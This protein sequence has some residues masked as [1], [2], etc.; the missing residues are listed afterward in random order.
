[1]LTATLEG[2][3]RDQKRQLDAL[4]IPSSRRAEWK[5]GA[6]KPTLAQIMVLAMVTNSDPK[7]LIAWLA[8]QEATPAQ[9]E[10]FRLHKAGP[11][12]AFLTAV[13]TVL[14]AT[15]DPAF[16]QCS[17]DQT[18]FAPRSDAIYIVEC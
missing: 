9:R 10:L 7:P 13:L 18:R 14:I 5:S 8:E 2:L 3:T 4:G 6:R 11:A 1:M 17:S 15:P 16:A 12:G